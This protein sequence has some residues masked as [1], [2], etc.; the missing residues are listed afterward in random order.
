[1]YVTYFEWEPSTFVWWQSNTNKQVMVCFHMRD[2]FFSL[3]LYFDLNVKVNFPL[4]LTKY[5][6]I[7]FFPVLK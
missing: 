2:L 3:L 5:H 6:A 1:M 4:C 7:K